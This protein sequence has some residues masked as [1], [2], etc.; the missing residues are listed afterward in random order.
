MSESATQFEVLSS[1]EVVETHGDN[2]ID[3]S[4]GCVSTANW[5]NFLGRAFLEMY[6]EGVEPRT[7]QYNGPHFAVFNERAQR[8]NEA[9]HAIDPSLTPNSLFGASYRGMKVIQAELELDSAQTRQLNDLR[10]SQKAELDIMATKL[11]PKIRG[12][13]IAEDSLDKT[14]YYRQ[15]EGTHGDTH[16]SCALAAYRMVFGAMAGWSP[17]EDNMA[18]HLKAYYNSAVVDDETYMKLFATEAFQKAAQL[19]VGSIDVVGADLACIDKLA[20]KIKN[21]RPNVSVYAVASLGRLNNDKL[22][23]AVWHKVVL[24]GTTES[25]VV[26]N[27]PSKDNGGEQI[28]ISQRDFIR[29]WIATSNTVRLVVAS[30]MQ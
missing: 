18:R 3:A 7:R 8:K 12:Q 1:P 9:L 11:E 20:Q 24:L 15:A 29:R 2:T 6:D 4:A 16:R 14:P 13:S 25:G 27:D 30:S 21:N 5:Q 26:C 10:H 17:S 19:S 23:D 28:E 22:I